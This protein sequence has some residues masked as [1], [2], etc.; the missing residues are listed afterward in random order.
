MEI[1]DLC[2]NLEVGGKSEL[3][4][5]VV[6]TLLDEDG[7]NGVTDGALWGD[8]HDLG[9]LVGQVHFKHVPLVLLEDVQVLRRE[10]KMGGGL[11]VLKMKK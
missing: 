3:H 9:D 7:S 11:N 4:D 1:F 10:K 5:L 8:G 2:T 6:V